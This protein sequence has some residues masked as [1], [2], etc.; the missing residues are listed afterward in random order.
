MR[1]ALTI[2]LA[3]VLAGSGLPPLAAK[4]M[5]PKKPKLEARALPAMGMVPVEILLVMDLKG[6]DDLED[7][8]CP[9]I[10]IDWDD[11]GKS[12]Q[13]SD[14]PPFEPGMKLTRH[15]TASHEYQRAGEFEVR[16]RLLHAEQTVAS[17]T[18]RLS[19]RPGLGGF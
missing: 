16:A 5:K 9:G 8:Y 12:A 7:F 4:D 13:E 14:C 19:L 3:L 2:T 6:G 11:G 15:F 1:T 18:V 17:A 10:E